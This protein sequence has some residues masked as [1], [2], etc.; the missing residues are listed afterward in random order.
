MSKDDV[1][2]IWS[3][4]FVLFRFC[5]V[6]HDVWFYCHVC[7]LG[8]CKNKNN[9]LKELMGFKASSYEEIILIKKGVKAVNRQ[10]T[11]HLKRHF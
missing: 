2:E 10:A 11:E 9:T 8:A 6:L 1:I 4:S 5:V 3:L 7:Y